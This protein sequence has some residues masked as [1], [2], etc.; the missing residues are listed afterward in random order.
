MVRL[1]SVEQYNPIYDIHCVKGVR[2]RSYSGPYSVRMRENTDQNNSEYGHFSRSDNGKNDDVINY[3]NNF[4]C[5]ELF[6]LVL[7]QSLML[8]VTVVT[9]A[10]FQGV[11][12]ASI[13]LIA[14]RLFTHMSLPCLDVDGL[15]FFH[16]L[17]YTWL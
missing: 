12:G 10:I 3:D 4:F 16:F 5:L 8:H 2:M 1:S 9:S 15:I 7:E 14:V 17:L 11:S 13:R 6:P